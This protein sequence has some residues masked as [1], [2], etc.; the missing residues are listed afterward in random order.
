VERGELSSAERAFQE[1]VGGLR[2]TH[3]QG[4]LVEAERQLAEVLLRQGK[5]NEAERIVTAAQR[6]VGRDDVWTRASMLHASGL[7]R[8]AQG[9]RDEACEEFSAALEI[10]EPTMYTILATEIRAS[11][12]ALSA[13]ADAIVERGIVPRA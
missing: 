3:E 8:A 13:C 7:V 4:Y 5:I 2:R 12:E 6:R 1:A 11:L 10:I 9:R